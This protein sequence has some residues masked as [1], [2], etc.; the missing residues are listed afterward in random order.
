MRELDVFQVRV[1]MP[2]HGPLLLLREIDG[3][4]YLPIWIGA[5]EAA[6]I[7]NAMDGVTP[8]RPLTHDLMATVL[9]ELGHERLEGRI[10][11]MEE[12]VYYGELDIDGHVV[13]ARPSDLVALSVRT[14]M[15]LKCPEELLE[16]VG[17]E[18]DVRPDD[19]MEKF[20]EFLE[21]VTPDDFE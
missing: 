18:L 3:R 6:A 20:R 19:E 16:Q 7:A 21:T 13:T 8:P 12:G 17:I 14:G 4:R 10:T 9:A 2:S 1:E 11:A 5:N 15:P